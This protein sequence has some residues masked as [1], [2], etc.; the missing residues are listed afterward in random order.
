MLEGSV[1][2]AREMAH[3]NELTSD[4][5]ASM[6]EMA[7]GAAQVNNTVQ[8]VNK[9]TLANKESIRGLSEEIRV[10]KVE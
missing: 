6:N 5:T 3:L 8:D 9:L 2:V 10:F 7:D 1:A 4:I